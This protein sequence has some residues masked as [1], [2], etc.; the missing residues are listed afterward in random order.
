MSHPEALPEGA[1]DSPLLSIVMPAYNYGE[2]VSRAV[3][4]VLAQMRPDCELVVIDDGSS[5]G[6][7]QVLEAIHAQNRPGFRWTR[8]ENAGAA[9]AR[10]AGMRSSRGAFLL[11]F[12]ADDELLP[13]ALDAVCGAIR[14]NPQASVILGGRITRRA[15]GH[16]KY[17]SP[18]AR[19]AADP[20]TR[21]AD[22]LVHK[23]IGMGHG[24]T[25]VKRELMAQRSYPENLQ[26]SE[27]IPVFA[28]L[29]AYGVFAMVDQPL[30]RIHKHHDSLRHLKPVADE[31][32][33]VLVAEI[34]GDL[35]AAC[36]KVRGPYAARRYLSL[37]RIALRAGDTAGA[38]RYLSQAA[39]MDFLQILKPGQVRKAL[40]AGLSALA[41]RSR[42]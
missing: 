39:K 33:T 4:S 23:R 18:P 21:I 25:V 14:A 9:A 15:E 34:F 27:D 11:F 2:V 5:D 32:A 38:R 40:K 28:F 3:E 7:P 6:T 1:P 19:L 36:M 42:D 31:R 22:Y 26:G 13:H 24:S 35:P 16:E 12:D 10:N 41:R 30:V 20:C 37:F 17:H 8:Q 29:F